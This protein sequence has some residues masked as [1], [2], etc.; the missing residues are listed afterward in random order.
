MCVTVHVFGGVCCR[1]S[2][3][4]HCCL[5]WDQ[6]TYY[7]GALMYIENTV[8]TAV[9]GTAVND[10]PLLLKVRNYLPINHNCKTPKFYF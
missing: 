10:I 9:D 5:I 3:G 6:T 4:A 7:L 1:R 8:L 2:H